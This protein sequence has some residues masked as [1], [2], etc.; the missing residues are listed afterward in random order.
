MAAT[1]S[2]ATPLSGVAGTTAAADAEPVTAMS[3]CTIEAVKLRVGRYSL[4]ID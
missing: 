3:E 1:V 4:R 2:A